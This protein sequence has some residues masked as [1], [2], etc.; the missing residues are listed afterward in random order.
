[1]ET[2]SR[3]DFRGIIGWN[4]KNS[5]LIEETLRLSN[6]YYGAKVDG[7]LIRNVHYTLYFKYDTMKDVIFFPIIIAKGGKCFK[8]KNADELAN[9]IEKPILDRCFEERIEKMTDCDYKQIRQH[10][11]AF[12]NRIPYDE[13]YNWY[14]DEFYGYRYVEF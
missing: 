13:L 10:E 9:F 5:P 2:I 8:A 11:I 3:K 12:S 4:Y 1:M 6:G 7:T 14:K